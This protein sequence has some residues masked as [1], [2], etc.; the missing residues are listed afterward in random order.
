M[1]SAWTGTGLSRPPAQNPGWDRTKIAFC[2]HLAPHL[3]WYSG[4]GPTPLWR[5]TR[6]ALEA[7][8]ASGGPV[9]LSRAEAEAFVARFADENAAVARDFL[10]RSDGELFREPIDGPDE[11]Q[12]PEIDPARMAELAARV[13]GDLA[14]A[15]PA[16]P[17]RPPG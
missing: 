8:P 17:P 16:R 6:R 9:R 5:R 7:A 1:R 15:P 14:A 11:A 10:D 13:I 4:G 12:L 2:Q 3:D